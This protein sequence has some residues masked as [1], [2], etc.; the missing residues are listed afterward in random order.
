MLLTLQTSSY[1][2]SRT[3]ARDFLQGNTYDIVPFS[4]AS[5]NI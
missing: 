5:A 1:I 2:L 3:L 4:Y